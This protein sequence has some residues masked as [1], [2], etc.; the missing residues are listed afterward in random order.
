MTE[1]I[2]PALKEYV[3]PAV[4]YTAPSPVTECVAGMFDKL[5]PVDEL[6]PFERMQQ[7]TVDVPMPQILKGAVE[8][9]EL[10]QVE[11]VQRQP[12]AQMLIE[13]VNVVEFAPCER[14]QQQFVGMPMPWIL[15]ETVEVTESVSP[16]SPVT[17][18]VPGL[19]TKNVAPI[20]AV[21]FDETAPMTKYVAPSPAMSNRE[22][23][24]LKKLGA[25]MTS[26]CSALKW[27]CNI[28]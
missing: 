9:G 22:K 12:M 26:R 18:T 1:Y 25:S 17:D 16:A 2:T 11:R 7:Q 19:A 21:T 10:V 28:R 3:S 14:V 4:T 24:S 27:E 15:K 23:K 20:R 5:F 6:A 8:V 13:T